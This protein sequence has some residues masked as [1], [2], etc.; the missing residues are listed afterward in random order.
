MA[1]ARSLPARRRLTR[2]SGLCPGCRLRARL[3]HAGRRRGPGDPVRWRSVGRPAR[4]HPGPDEA[5]RG[6]RA[7][8]PPGWAAPPTARAPSPKSR[9]P[10]P[11]RIRPLRARLAA[12]GGRLLQRIAEPDRR[13]EEYRLFL[14]TIAPLGADA[15]DAAPGVPLTEARLL[16]VAALAE[17]DAERALSLAHT[18]NL[19]PPATD[20]AYAALAPR[21]APTK[22]QEALALADQVASPELR[23]RTLWGLAESRP[24]TEAQA[25][26][27]RVQDP[28][29]R[30]GLLASAAWRLAAT[31][32]A[33]A[34]T[35]LGRW[36]SPLPPPRRKWPSPSPAGTRPGGWNSRGSSPRPTVPG[37][38]VRS[39]RPSPRASRS[40]RRPTCKRPV[41]GPN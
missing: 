15:P 35:W 11:R 30:A 10:S 5:G 7:R 31:D 37:P 23:D 26:A 3:S 6:R 18:W 22:P 2:L 14:H 21:L 41:A 16:V 32:P 8:P 38:S 27:A 4:D 36:A 13:A 1:A 9:P 29:L 39:P 25:V 28:V 17:T 19:K 40:A 20:A 12:L 24:V 34:W 33:A